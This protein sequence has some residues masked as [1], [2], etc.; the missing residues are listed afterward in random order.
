[1]SNRKNDLSHEANYK[2]S[3]KEQ[4]AVEKDDENENLTVHQ[5]EE[6]QKNEYHS[7]QQYRLEGKAENGKS[8]FDLMKSKRAINPLQQ[9]KLRI[10]DKL[11]ARGF[12]AQLP[13]DMYGDEYSD[14]PRYHVVKSTGEQRSDDLSYPKIPNYDL[15]KKREIKNENLASGFRIDENGIIVANETKPRDVES[16]RHFNEKPTN[17]EGKNI[18]ENNKR[19]NYDYEMETEKVFNYDSNEKDVNDEFYNN[20]EQ[21][22]KSTDDN[23][24]SQLQQLQQLQ[25]GMA[26]I[27][28]FKNEPT[29]EKLNQNIKTKSDVCSNVDE[30]GNNLC[31]LKNDSAAFNA[32]DWNTAIMENDISPNEHSNKSINLN[33]D[34]MLKINGKNLTVSN[35]Q[36]DEFGL[37]LKRSVFD[38]KRSTDG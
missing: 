7:Q 3:K 15:F 10:S 35:E 9:I 5:R 2:L 36:N 34:L 12:G 14:W 33:L 11:I 31:K 8:Q 21:E 23:K 16:N 20:D 29:N 4:E 1:M 37:K 25:H 32:T 13:S 6:Q 18:N 26:K 28:T 22:N 19:N 30:I 24:Q 38:G 17:G 27:K